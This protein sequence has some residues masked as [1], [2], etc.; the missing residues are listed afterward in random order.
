M[1]P[2]RAVRCANWFLW[3]FGRKFVPL[4]I[5]RWRVVGKAPHVKLARTSHQV[6]WHMVRADDTL[7]ENATA[8]DRFAAEH[9]DE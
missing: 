1:M 6:G 3:L 5:G 2:A 4:N 7:P 8:L 9:R